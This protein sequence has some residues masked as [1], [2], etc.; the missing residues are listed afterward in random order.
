MLFLHVTK[1]HFIITCV[2]FT[3]IIITTATVIVIAV[4]NLIP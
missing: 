2:V 3:L 1:T 4:M